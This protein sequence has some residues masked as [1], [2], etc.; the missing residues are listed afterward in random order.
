M[1]DASSTWRRSRRELAAGRLQTAAHGV[2]RGGPLDSAI[3]GEA[4]R[5]SLSVVAA[6]S[7]VLATGSLAA[8]DWPHWR[9]PLAS[10]VSTETGLPERWSATQNVAWKAALAGVGVSSP[11]VCRRSGVR[12]LA[13]RRRRAS[14]GQPSAP[15]AGR[16]RGRVGRARADRGR[17]Q[18]QDVFRRPGVRARGRPPALGA[19]DGGGAASCRAC[20]TSTTWRR[21]ARSATAGWSMRGSR[22]ARSW[23]SIGPARLVWSRHLGQEISPVRHQLGPQQLADAA[24]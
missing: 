5:D 9:G 8:A 3:P 10:G 24:R 11:I 22:R 20:T 13:G 2:E 23:R 14:A 18:R 19:P 1:G 7:L 15:G 16:Q 12:D 17:R 6:V 4:R 21:R